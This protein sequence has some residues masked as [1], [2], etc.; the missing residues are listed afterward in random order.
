MHRRLY[1]K[2][3]IKNLILLLLCF[4]VFLCA[5][6]YV[7]DTNSKQDRLDALEK[8]AVAIASS[9]F[10]TNSLNYS[11]D[12]I[13]KLAVTF[14]AVDKS[15][16]LL[17]SN[18]GSVLVCSDISSENSC[19]HLSYTFDKSTVYSIF[20]KGSYSALSDL[21]GLYTKNHY[22]VGVPIESENN[23][24]VA[25]IIIGRE[26]KTQH[27]LLRVL[28]LSAI[29]LVV[30]IL[31][32]IFSIR[33]IANSTVKPLKQVS[34]A[35]KAVSKGDFSVRVDVKGND[36]IEEF[37]LL[38]NKMA[39]SLSSLEEMSSSF[40]TNVSHD[41]KTPMTTVSGFIDAILDGTMPASEHKKYLSIVSAEIKRLSNTVNTMMTLSKVQ[42][43]LDKLSYSQVDIIDLICRVVFSFEA[44]L[45]DKNIDVLGLDYNGKILVDCNENMIYQA[46]YNL[47]DNAVKFTQNG[48]YIS[49]YFSENNSSLEM[50]IK[51]SG[52]GISQ[53]DIV[54]VFERFYK[55]DKTRNVDKYGAGIGLYIVKNIIDNHDGEISVK[56][57]EGQYAE[58][59]VKL[60]KSHNKNTLRAENEQKQ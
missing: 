30:V 37:A 17:V 8:E 14:S 9:P 32:M 4:V 15:S 46:I 50:Y 55:T 31:L 40:I 38:F 24:D 60:P 33:R 35:I 44:T 2:L 41:L 36:E 51:N 16:V 7:V 57:L 23:S 29:P 42:T 18:S 48:G 3:F 34:D 27:Y 53:N 22:V 54:H 59:C 26:L 39:D 56:S 43:G 12:E 28:K 13:K 1:I 47:V 49:F 10:L 58:F 25:V 5:S 11:S 19:K 20:Q 21:N 45:V 6:A 52:D